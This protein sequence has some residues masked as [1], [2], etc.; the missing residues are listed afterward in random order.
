MAAIPNFSFFPADDE[1]GERLR[2]KPKY[3]SNPLTTTEK[4][5]PN[6]NCEYVPRQNCTQIPRQVCEQ[7]SNLIAVMTVLSYEACMGF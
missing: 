6:V 1:T 2:H 5:A 3:G 4:I 7:G